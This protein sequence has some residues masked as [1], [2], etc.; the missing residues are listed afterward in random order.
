MFLGEV[1]S[2]QGLP[3]GNI[4]VTATKDG[5]TKELTCNNTGWKIENLELGI[6]NRE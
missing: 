4:K 6:Y 3:E 5:I 1:I 2:F